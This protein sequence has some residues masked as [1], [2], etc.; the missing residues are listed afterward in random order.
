MGFFFE[1]KL[2]I[3]IGLVCFFLL[4]EQFFY[5]N[6]VS[7]KEKKKKFIHIS[8][9]AIISGSLVS[10]FGV[11][12]LVWFS[13]VWEQSP[14]RV[15]SSHNYVLA[16]IIGWLLLEFSVYV[17]HRCAHSF[18]LLWKF[19]RVHHRDQNLD[20]LSALR[21]HPIEV[22]YFF[23][24][25][26]V[27]VVLGVPVPAILIFE[28]SVGSF[29]L[30]NHS[31]VKLPQKLDRILKWVLITPNRHHYHHHALDGDTQTNF[32]FCFSIWDII[33]GTFN[34]K[35][36]KPELH[37]GVLEKVDSGTGEKDSVKTVTVQ[38]SNIEKDPIHIV[39]FLRMPFK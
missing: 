25:K 14:L 9:L 1:N 20:C 7:L 13:G 17:A 2:I 37:Y 11:L 15:L 3:F 12:F 18:P 36:G 21:F 19:H 29:A 27:V 24:F 6:K 5:L 8:L 31:N 10:P 30:F 38:K 23:L 32:G 39:E 33:F 28:M 4:L 16:A 26:A 35:T 22:G 34:K